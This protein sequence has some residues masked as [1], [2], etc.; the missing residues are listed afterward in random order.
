GLNLYDLHG[1]ALVWSDPLAHTEDL[2]RLAFSADGTLLASAGFDGLARLWRVLPEGR[3]QPLHVLTGH[4]DAVHA[5]A[6]S[7]D[8]RLLA[9]AGYDGRVGVFDTASGA[10]KF[11]AAGKGQVLSVA[12]G[13]GG[14]RIYVADRDDGR[15]RVWQIAGDPPVMQRELDAARDFLMWAEPDVEGRQIAAVGRDYVVSILDLGTGDLLHSLPG[16]ENAVFKARFLPGGGQLA[17]AGVDATVRFWDL[18]TASELF[19]LRLPTNQRQPV[20][21]WDFDLRCAPAACWLAVPLTRGKLAL[22]QLAQP[23]ALP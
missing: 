5:V 3:L 23:P 18:E 17:T 16:H 2:Q 12:F 10:G 20:P 13:P 9:T 21:L 8:G 1:L 22:Y 4:T 15:I 14:Q 6:F 19:T 11:F 7:P